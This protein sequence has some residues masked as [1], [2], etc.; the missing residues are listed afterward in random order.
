[1][2]INIK[3]PRHLKLH[4]HMLIAQRSVQFSF[5]KP[6]RMETVQSLWGPV[7]S[8]LS[9]EKSPGCAPGPPH[10]CECC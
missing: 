6:A 1:M 5:E 9:H 8:W 2:E 4:T 3:M 7:S 10:D